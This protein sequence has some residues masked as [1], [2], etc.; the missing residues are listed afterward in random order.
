MRY[1]TGLRKVPS[2][3][4]VLVEASY[5]K[6]FKKVLFSVKGLK[7]NPAGEIEAGKALSLPA[8][9]GTVVYN[10][11]QAT[12]YLRVHQ[13]TAVSNVVTMVMTAKTR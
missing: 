13:G 6:D 2:T 12:W 1:I 4:L 9:Y 5:T 11:S 8:P 7:P 3:A 10:S